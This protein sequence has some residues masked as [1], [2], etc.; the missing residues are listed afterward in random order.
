[1]CPFFSIFSV[2]FF[3]IF[4]LCVG[5]F[6]VKKAPKHSTELLSG[7]SKHKKVVTLLTKKIYVRLILFR[8]EIWCCW[9]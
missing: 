6:T 8:H 5:D 9:P 7:I 4:A 3:C 2:V 1:M